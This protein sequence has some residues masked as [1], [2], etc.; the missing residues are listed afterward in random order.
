M[1]YHLSLWILGRAGVASHEWW[2]PILILPV[3]WLVFRA[4]AAIHIGIDSRRRAHPG[5]AADLRSEPIDR[6]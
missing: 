2:L 1:G 5:T 4:I 6:T 3:I